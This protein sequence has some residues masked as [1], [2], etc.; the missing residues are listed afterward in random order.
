MNVLGILNGGSAKVKRLAEVT[1]TIESSRLNFRLQADRINAA[2]E[3]LVH[4]LYGLDARFPEAVSPFSE[5]L[6]IH[7]PWSAKHYQAWDI[8]ATDRVLMFRLSQE[9]RSLPV[10]EQLIL[11]HR[12]RWHLNRAH[13][14]DLAGA[15]GWLQLN[16]VNGRI[17]QDLYR[18]GAM[19][20]GS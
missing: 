14:P 17:V 7:V 19:A 1:A 2:L 20:L 11:F 12:Q 9:W 15:Q 8:T 18:N 6:L 5:E 10:A 13:Y 16:R 4:I 3:R